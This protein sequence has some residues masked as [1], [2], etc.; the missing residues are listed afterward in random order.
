MDMTALFTVALGL[1]EP[2]YVD[3]IEFKSIQ[4]EAGYPPSLHIWLKFRRGSRFPCPVN[5]RA[6]LA[7]PQLFSVQDFPTCQ[8]AENPLLPARGSYGAGPM[9]KAG[10]RFY[11]A[12]RVDDPPHGF[13]TTRLRHS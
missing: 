12:L 11:A 2:W 9:G 8:R 13:A 7:A 1:Q 6:H 4:E 10:F 5:R 3:K